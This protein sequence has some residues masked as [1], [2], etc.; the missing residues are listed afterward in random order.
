MKVP[1]AKPW[2]DK[3][4]IEAVTD[5]LK[6][7]QLS[8]GRMVERFENVVAKYSRTDY[9]V[10]TSSGTAA[11]HLSLL[12]NFTTQCQAS[13]KMNGKRVMVPSFTFPATINAVLHAG[14]KPIFCD[15]DRETYNMIDP[16]HPR[17]AVMPVSQFGLPSSFPGTIHDAACGLG[18][19]KHPPN[20]ETTLCAATCFSFHP[21]KIITTGEGGM[22]V[23]NNMYVAQEARLLRDHGH[24]REETFPMTVHDP[25][26]SE[27]E[28]M[29]CTIY[30]KW[31]PGGYNMRM[32]DLAAAIGIEQMK[33]LPQILERRQEIA[34]YYFQE[35]P[36]ELH[37]PSSILEQNYQ[38]YVCT[39]DG[40]RDKLI[41]DLAER[42]VECQVGS[43]ACHRI[44]GLD[45]KDFPNSSYLADHTLALPIYPQ[46]TQEEQDYV[47]E[48]IKEVLK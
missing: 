5:V 1:L 48:M 19:V 20:K 30:E 47:I 42:G 13:R 27:P 2:I 18:S 3:S 29:Q 16:G 32:T 46:M 38:S 7:G 11:L 17:A 15:V 6:S 25:C 44:W 37:C 24:Q 28:D 26:K 34:S 12:A 43:Y 14:L 33:R 10:A 23:T 22:I 41:K 8:M 45:D 36:D 9:A 40:D 35:L 39:F 4:E 31:T 21:R